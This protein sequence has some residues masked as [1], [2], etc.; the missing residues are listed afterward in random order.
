[1]DNMYCVYVLTNSTGIYYIG[2]TSN[3]VIRLSWHNSD[4]SRYTKNK[5]PWRVIFQK[6]FNTKSEAIKYK[7]Y[8]KSLK[9]KKYLQNNINI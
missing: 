9:N 1:M 7:K 2:Y 4:K 5:G 8:L 3:L 6:P